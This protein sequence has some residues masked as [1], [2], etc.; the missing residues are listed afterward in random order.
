ME[1]I[2]IR[3]MKATDIKDVLVV[4]NACF[5]TPWT[6]NA[7]EMEIKKNKLAIYLVATIEDKVVGYGGMWLV[8]DEAHITNVAVHPEYQGKKIGEAIVK[9]LTREAEE[10]G[11]E[12]MTLEVRKSNIPAQNLYKKIQ[13]IMCGIRPSYYSDNGEDAL[14]M[15]KELE[16]T[17]M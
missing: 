3:K 1:D 11:S 13:F 15:W 10:K 7:F 16:K 6:K 14:I 17:S 5:S 8:V 4:E 9:G 12:R 2:H